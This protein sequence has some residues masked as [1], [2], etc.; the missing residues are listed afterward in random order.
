[1]I[2]VLI[3]LLLIFSPV[4]LAWETTCGKVK[5]V[6]SWSSGSDRYGLRA[7]LTN[8]PESCTGFW[9]AHQDENKQFAFSMLLSSAASGIKTCIQY[10]P[11]LTKYDGMCKLNHVYIET[12]H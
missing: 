7:T 5:R 10:D 9:I 11:D 3:S 4:C 1:M 2:R 6:F 8:L 12:K